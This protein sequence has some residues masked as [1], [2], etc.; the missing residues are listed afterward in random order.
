MKLT[1]EY[2]VGTGWD[3]EAI[4]QVRYTVETKEGKK[5]LVF[6][7]FS[8]CPEDATFNR[9]LSDVLEIGELIHLAYQAGVQGED[10]ETKERDCTNCDC[11]DCDCE[12]DT[13]KC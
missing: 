2:D 4:A 3:D 10:W 1:T 9:G 11:D 12:G 13:C 5:Q 8:D 6:N 7:E